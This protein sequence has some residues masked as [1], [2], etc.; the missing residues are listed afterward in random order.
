MATEESPLLGSGSADPE[1]IQHEAIY[2]RFSPAQKRGVVAVV[3]AAGWIPFF[4]SG[5]FIPAIPQISEE[6]HTTGAIV[7]LAVSLSI[8]T[9]SIGSLFWA[10]YSGFYGRRSIYVASIVV[11]CIGSFGVSMARDVPELLVTRI[12]QAFGAS[13]GLSV[14]VACIGD[15]YK[16]EERGTAT[17]I[18]F[19]A[20]LF[21]P[22]LA[23]VAGGVTAHYYSWRVMQVILG[24]CAGVMLL[25]VLA[26]LPETS[27]PGT[28]GVDKMI[29][30]DGKSG[31][32]WL[33][34]FKAI[35]LLRSP[36]VFLVALGGG[37]CLIT[38]YVLLVPIAY[39]LGAKHGITNE[40]IIGA[41]FI[42][43]GLGNLLGAPLAG[44]NSDKIVKKWRQKRG[45]WYPEDRLR[46]TLT[47]ALIYVPVSVLLFG[48]FVEN[49]EGKLGIALALV[50][51]FING[52]GV[53]YVLSPSAAYNVD[54]LHSRS[55][56]VM[57]ANAGFRG[58]FIALATSFLYPMI[59]NVG[60]VTTN[61]IAAVLGWLGFF[62]LWSVVRYGD[63]MRASVDVG[64][65]TLRDN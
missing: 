13:S 25:V 32:V 46:A 24:V 8:L 57:A 60:V 4:V 45:T 1:V 20:I 5:T 42:P 14:G 35:A 34:P 63:R 47:G 15:I 3:S 49:V 18:F 40:A 37:L 31:W 19:G 64:F 28:R 62:A 61:S 55:A 59:E 12:V 58:I 48:I 21:G 50:C 9:N 56:E 22:A 53:D 16:L 10:T 29:E 54:I 7:S 36:N 30:K 33:N 52:I 38:D 2:L 23:P 39:T 51:L 41:F 65:S 43:A 11:L 44:R 6:L 26:F 17:G 27:H